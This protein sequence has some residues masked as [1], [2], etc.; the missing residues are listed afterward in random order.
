MWFLCVFYHRLL[1]YR[2]AEVESLAELFGGPFG[3]NG[4]A[5]AKLEWRLPLHH[6][7]DSPFHFVN[8]PSDDLARRIATRSQPFPSS[9]VDLSFLY[10]IDEL[11]P[12]F[13]HL[14]FVSFL[15]RYTGEGDV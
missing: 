9:F 14:I 4:D 2:K 15:C 5:K 1:D 13:F 11:G 3:E 7:P 12:S 8:L 6:H 10:K